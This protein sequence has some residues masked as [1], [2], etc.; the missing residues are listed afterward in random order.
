MSMESKQQQQHEGRVAHVAARFFRRRRISGY[1]VGVASLLNVGCYTAGPLMSEPEPAQRVVLTLNDRGR[2][3]LSEQ[4]GGG[5]VSVE[6]IVESTDNAAYVMRVSRV[7]YIASP[8]TTWTGERVRIGKD[9]VGMSQAR[10]LSKGRTFLAIG[11][12]GLAFGIFAA[13]RGLIG[14][15]SDPAPP[16][17][18]PGQS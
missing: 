15:G 7:T 4:L 16:P 5:P 13:T 18:T 9:G 3:A 17:I 8:A 14:W 2:A 6:G 11:I 1:V 12:A 10:Q